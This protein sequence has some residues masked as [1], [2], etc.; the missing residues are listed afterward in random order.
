M[1]VLFRSD[2]IGS[3]LDGKINSYAIVEGTATVA[4]NDTK[5]PGD[6]SKIR[7]QIE[8]QS[9]TTETRKLYDVM[10]EKAG[11]VVADKDA[12]GREQPLKLRVNLDCQATQT[13][14]RDIHISFCVDHMPAAEVLKLIKS[15]GDEN[16]EFPA[17][18]A[19]RMLI[20]ENQNFSM[21]L[22]GKEGFHA[23][24]TASLGVLESADTRIPAALLSASVDGQM[25]KLSEKDFLDLGK[26]EVSL[27]SRLNILWDEQGKLSLQYQKPDGKYV[28]YDTKKHF[29][30]DLSDDNVLELLGLAFSAVA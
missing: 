19:L 30:M 21:H 17:S 22:K 1:G 18:L 20:K 8:Y 23:G 5:V 24:F 15:V 9:S 6:G 26:V 13:G 4:P 27:D 12:R 2:K 16:I 10:K 29:G 28:T 25:V 11:D 14:L 3:W 7:V